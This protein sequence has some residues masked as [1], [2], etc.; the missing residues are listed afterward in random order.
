MSNLIASTSAVQIR[1][2]DLH[3]HF[4][5]WRA[6]G[7]ELDGL[8]AGLLCRVASGKQHAPLSVR[9]ALGLVKPRRNVKKIVMS[10]LGLPWLTT[11]L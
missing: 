2:N 7:A 11:G 8:D 3:R 6:V 1:L 10:A 4:V 9:R 5:T